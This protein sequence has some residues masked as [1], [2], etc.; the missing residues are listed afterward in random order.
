MKPHSEKFLQKRRFF[1]VLPLLVLPFVTMIFWALGGGQGTAAQAKAIPQNGLNL[2]LPDA[3]F[4][5][6]EIWDKLTL[7]EMAQRDSAKYEEARE[8]DPYFDLIAFKTQDQ[9]PEKKEQEKESKLI[10]SFPQ[11]ERQPI[12]PNE[13]R[14]TKKLQ[15]LY[16][17]INRSQTNSPAIDSH[18][19]SARNKPLTTET[20]SDPQ[21][22]ADVDRLERMMEM[23]QDDGASDPEMQQI[24][25]VLEKILDIQ[26]PQRV[27]ERLKAQTQQQK[28]NTHSV[29]AMKG[30]DNISVI[31]TNVAG[32]LG[33]ADSLSAVPEIFTVQP[34]VNGFFGLDN[35]VA[36]EPRAG[37]GIEAVI[38]DTQELVVGA[39]VKLRLLNDVMINGRQVPKDQFIYGTCAINGERLTIQVNSIRTGNTLLPV[40]LS[41]YDLDGLEG[42]YIPGAITRDAAKQASDDALQNI[43][44]TTLDPSIGAQAAAAGVE[45]AK[46]LFS[47]KAKLVKVTVKAGYQVFLVDTNPTSDTT[48]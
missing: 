7:Y 12:D 42:I 24:E 14:V 1:M 39:T 41:V 29:Q 20:N 2:S 27:K 6:Q 40:S 28:S 33:F 13:E 31:N 4:G 34:V 46:G 43:Q 25:S 9:Q 21:F 8:S 23:M 36:Y 38:H 44:L 26:H 15:E 32:S 30:D 10:S 16:S 48:Y 35:E 19:Q 3:H 22:T 37:N 17:E 5:E 47:K 45:A 18:Q 11:K